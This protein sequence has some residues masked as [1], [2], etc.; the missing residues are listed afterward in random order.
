MCPKCARRRRGDQCALPQS[1]HLYMSLS[2][3]ACVRN[4]KMRLCTRGLMYVPAAT[5]ATSCMCAS[6]NVTLQSRCTGRRGGKQ[7]VWALMKT[8]G[9]AAFVAHQPPQPQTPTCPSNDDDAACAQ[10]TP[11]ALAQSFQRGHP[12]ALPLPSRDLCQEPPPSTHPPQTSRQTPCRCRP[13]SAWARC[14]G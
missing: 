11:T 8:L 6:R 5:R 9:K 2:S 1:P 4:W 13:C 7:R 12:S 14:T 3:S 10:L